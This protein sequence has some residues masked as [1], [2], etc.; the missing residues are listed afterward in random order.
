M[1]DNMTKDGLPQKYSKAVIAIHWISAVL[2]LSL[3]PLGK[4]LSNLEP[5]D[6]LPFIKIHAILGC[7]VFVLTLVRCVLFFT[8]DRPEHLST[9]SKF[10]DFLA[11]AIHRA[12]YVLLLIIG[13][14]GIVTLVLGGYIDAITTAS[15]SAIL[16]K[17]EIM[18]LKIHNILAIIIMGLFVMHV[19]G[20]IRYNIKNKVN[21]IK[22][23]IS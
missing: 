3:F 17:N 12:F 19:A 9:G 23:R 11:K 6:K 20:V 22:E 10:N 21:V 7:I 2:I 5:I 4:Y 8:T 1:S 14:S 18:S 15:P 16:P 13:I